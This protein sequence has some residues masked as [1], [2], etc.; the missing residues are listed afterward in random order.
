MLYIGKR[1]TTTDF[2]GELR[3]HEQFWMEG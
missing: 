2:S 1:V 3:G